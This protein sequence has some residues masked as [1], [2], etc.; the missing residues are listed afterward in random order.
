MPGRAAAKMEGLKGHTKFLLR[1]NPCENLVSSQSKR[2]KVT[3][4]VVPN[5][6]YRIMNED[7]YQ[8]GT[9]IVIP[10]SL[11]GLATAILVTGRALFATQKSAVGMEVIVLT[12]RILIVASLTLL[13]S[14]IINVICWLIPLSVGGK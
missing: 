2:V 14:E 10:S 11:I 3:F 6:I 1:C 5:A 4:P 12:G 8:A 9:L 13:C 7:Y